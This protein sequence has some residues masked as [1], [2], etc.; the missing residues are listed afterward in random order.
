MQSDTDPVCNR[1]RPGKEQYPQ[2]KN[3]VECVQDHPG[4]KSPS[5]TFPAKETKERKNS[6]DQDTDDQTGDLR[7]YRK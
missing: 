2:V 3:S 4:Q 1:S 5:G 6:R 7:R